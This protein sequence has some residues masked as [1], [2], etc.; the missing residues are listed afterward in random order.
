VKKFE[1]CIL[2]VDL[3]EIP[4]YAKIY[5]KIL[6]KC[7]EDFNEENYAGGLAVSLRE[8]TYRSILEPHLLVAMKKKGIEEI[9]CCVYLNM[10]EEEERG[11]YV[12][13]GLPISKRDMKKLKKYPINK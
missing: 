10:T 6:K 9:Q 1:I 5:K 3:I 13:S 12:L 11:A 2:P 4:I 7:I 8:E